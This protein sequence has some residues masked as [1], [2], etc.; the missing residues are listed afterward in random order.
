MEQAQ[1]PEAQTALI[2]RLILF[3]LAVAV[4]VVHTTRKKMVLTEVLAAALEINPVTVRRG[5][6]TLAATHPQKETMAAKV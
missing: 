1:A 5:P 4:V 3:L 2:A 6:V